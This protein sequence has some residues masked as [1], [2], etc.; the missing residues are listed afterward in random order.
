[1][2]FFTGKCMAAI[3]FMA[4]SLCLYSAEAAATGNILVSLP[5]GGTAL[6][7]NTVS[8]PGFRVGAAVL[9]PDGVY[10]NGDRV[11]LTGAGGPCSK[12]LQA[13]LKG[14]ADDETLHASDIGITYVY[15]YADPSWHPAQALPGDLASLVFQNG[16]TTFV[17]RGTNIGYRLEETNGSLIISADINGSVASSELSQQ[18]SGYAVSG[19]S[20]LTGASGKTLN[21]TIQD[22]GPSSGAVYIYQPEGRF[23]LSAT[24]APVNT[25]ILYNGLRPL[26]SWWVLYDKRHTT[27]L[28]A[29]SASTEPCGRGE[30][31][32]ASGFACYGG[33][34]R[35][36]GAGAS[37]A[38]I[39]ADSKNTLN[40]TAVCSYTAPSSLVHDFGT[41]PLNQVRDD[42]I[43]EPV[44]GTSPKLETYSILCQGTDVSKIAVR[45]LGD[46]SANAP[47][48]R[49]S[50]TNPSVDYIVGMQP[51]ADTGPIALTPN[52]VRIFSLKEMGIPAQAESIHLL[53]SA[54]PIVA[55]TSLLAGTARANLTVELWPMV[56]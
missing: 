21:F 33:F 19:Q 1:M 22:A 23:K 14:G 31:T 15:G 45:V 37:D 28:A 39:G 55:S 18:T 43:G 7:N 52:Q 34:D 26:I 51:N 46:A 53:L 6:C 35:A 40:S 42:T 47:G 54:Q 41:V 24:S 56:E 48:S 16:R 30:L 29:L 3:A 5:E 20:V 10:N 25:N 2:P 44:A 11:V 38:I 13:T 12:T 27:A 9:L 36:T 8:G 49:F 17:G 50:S 32:S 4:M